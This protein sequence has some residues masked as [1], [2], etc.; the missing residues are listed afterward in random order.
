[1]ADGPAEKILADAPL[2]EHHGLEVPYRL[3]PR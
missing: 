1:V 2:M 3:Q